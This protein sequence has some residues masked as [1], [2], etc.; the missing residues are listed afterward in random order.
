MKRGVQVS[1]RELLN[2]NR[3]P[4]QSHVTIIR[5]PLLLVTRIIAILISLIKCVPQNKNHLPICEPAL[6]NKLRLT[7]SFKVLRYFAV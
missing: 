5:L 6:N 7:T 2:E 1:K 4:R 3:T